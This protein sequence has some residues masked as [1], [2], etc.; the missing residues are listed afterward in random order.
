MQFVSVLAIT[1]LALCSSASGGEYRDRGDWPMYGRNLR[2][3]FSNWA[4]LLASA[5]AASLRGLRASSC[6]SHGRPGEPQAC[7]HDGSP[8][9]RPLPAIDAAVRC[10]LG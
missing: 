3:T 1:L 4:V 2:H 5:T 7:W 9:W 6:V 10:Q 8:P